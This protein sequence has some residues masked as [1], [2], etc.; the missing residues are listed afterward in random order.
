MFY[1]DLGFCWWELAGLWIANNPFI[2]VSRAGATMS[3][4]NIN[5][6]I[7]SLSVTLEIIS[8]DQ[9]LPKPTLKLRSK[10]TMRVRYFHSES[11]SKHYYHWEQKRKLRSLSNKVCNR[12]TDPG[13]TR[14]IGAIRKS[15]HSSLILWTMV[16]QQNFFA[17]YYV[18][19][20]DQKWAQLGCDRLQSIIL[21]SYHQF[22][23]TLH[24]RFAATILISPCRM[25]EY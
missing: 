3:L 6:A 17:A 22:G 5:R 25:T 2:A 18:K 7:R 9:Q 11:P 23:K 1:W 21:Q 4:W 12:S 14:T 19:Y 20:Q 15:L 24:V 10:V 13:R 16:T 8:R